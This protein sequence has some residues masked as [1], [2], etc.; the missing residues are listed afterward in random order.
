LLIV[1]VVGL[2]A[3]WLLW[4][5]RGKSA[6]DAQAAALEADTRTTTGTELPS[7]LTAV[8]AGQRAL[9]GLHC[10]PPWP[11]SSTGGTSWPSAHPTIAEGP[12]PGEIRNLLQELRSRRR[13]EPGA[14]SRA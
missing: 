3:G 6:W 12:G 2:I 1:L 9:R 5:S 13:R 7:V 14:G 4:R 11:T 8:T 10:G